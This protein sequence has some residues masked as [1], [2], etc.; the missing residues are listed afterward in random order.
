MSKDEIFA[1]VLKRRNLKQFQFS[2]FTA[3][4]QMRYY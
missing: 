4:N 1:I 2:H 3:D